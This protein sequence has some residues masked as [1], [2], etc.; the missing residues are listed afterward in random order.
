MRRRRFFGTAES[1]K[2]DEVELQADAFANAKDL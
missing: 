1:F 2:V